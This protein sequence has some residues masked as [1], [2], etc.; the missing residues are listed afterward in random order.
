MPAR[1]TVHLPFQPAKVFFLDD[2]QAYVLGR[3]PECELVVEDDRIS[4]RH[5]RIAHGAAGWVLDE[6]GSKNG[7]LLNGAKALQNAQA[8]LAAREGESAWLSF[9]GVVGKFD[10][11][12]KAAEGAW[13]AEQSLRWQTSVRWAESLNP[14]DGLDILLQSLMA[15]AIAASGTERGFILLLGPEGG[16]ELAQASGISASDL[17]SASFSGSL[18][19]VE[20]AMDLAVS[21]VVSD[22]QSDEFLKDR[23]SIVAGSIQTVV[24]VPLKVFGRVIGV[25]YA[26]SPKSGAT[27][28]DFDVELLEVVVSQAAIALWAARLNHEI[29]GLMGSLAEHAKAGEADAAAIHQELSDSCARMEAS[30]GPAQND[31]A[32]EGRHILKNAWHEMVQAFWRKGRP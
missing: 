1:L 29:H 12:G 7:T 5:A 23:A 4:R 15:S 14:A 17:D 8:I 19:A 32:G 21:V 2:Q 3:D 11:V 20:R 28:T 26:D 30:Y 22:V 24:C 27:F 18:G 16:L 9:G 31:A 13:N 10:A 6:L 25:V